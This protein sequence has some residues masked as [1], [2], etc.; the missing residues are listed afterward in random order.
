MSAELKAAYFAGDSSVSNE[1]RDLVVAPLKEAEEIKLNNTRL[2][3]AEALRKKLNLTVI[4]YNEYIT[5]KGEV[6]LFFL[7]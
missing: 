5:Q 2:A 4:E 6:F 3:T 1:Q 7:N